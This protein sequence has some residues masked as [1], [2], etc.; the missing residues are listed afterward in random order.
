MGVDFRASDLMRNLVMSGYMHLPIEKQEDIY[1]QFFVEI[2]ERQFPN[3]DK[4]DAFLQKFLEKK[5]FHFLGLVNDL[6]AQEANPRHVGS[7]EKTVMAFIKSNV[8]KNM[9]RGKSYTPNTQT[10]MA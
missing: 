9:K 5:N 4:M 10:G 3:P 6:D 7:F 1:Q 2:L 8:S